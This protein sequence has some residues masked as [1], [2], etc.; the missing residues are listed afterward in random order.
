MRH[1]LLFG[2]LPRLGK[3]KTRLVPPLSPRQALQLYQ[4]FLED[5]LA[6]LRGFAESAHVAW[7]VDAEP[8]PVER[9]RFPLDNVDIQLQ[10]SAD[11]GTR[12]LHAFE[13]SCGRDRG[14]TVIVGADCPTLP[15]AHVRRAFEALEEGAPAVIAPASDGGYVLV[16]MNEPRP[17]LFVGIAWGEADV[18]QTTRRRA[19]QARI[20]LVEIEPWYDV[21]D[22]DSLRR[23]R[24]ELSRPPGTARAPA[25]ALCLLDPGLSSV[26]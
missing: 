20:D 9:A 15:R 14:A 1:L 23:L 25:T 26:L 13:Q 11:L 19:E 5:Q 12:M 16:G 4:A 2:K 7:W 3:V 18:A 17:E 22:L 21:D 10:V 24:E 8:R 6:F